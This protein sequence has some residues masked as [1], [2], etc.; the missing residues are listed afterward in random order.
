VPDAGPLRVGISGSY[1]GLN[2]GDEAILESMVTQLRKTLPVEITV[3]TRDAEDTRRR[4]NVEHALLVRTLSREEVLPHI[5]A[6]DLFLL[7]GGG[8]LFDHWVKL[9]L[10]EAVLAQELGI[11]VFVYAVS[12]GPLSEPTAVRAV[13][14]CLEKAVGVTVRDASTLHR[15]EEIG[16]K[17]EIMLT[18]DP[19]FL[20]EPEPL[21]EDALL[22]EGLDSGRPLVGC[23]CGS[24]ARLHLAW[25]L[26]TI[27]RSSPTPPTTCGTVRCRYR[28][29]AH[30]AFGAGCAACLRSHVGHAQASSGGSSQRRVLCAPAYNARG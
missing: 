12:A 16:V 10:R 26:L 8:I 30:G 3:F 24:R 29:R 4:H 18:A 25:S 2:L 19:A 23:P 5:K 15:L 20:L 9:F 21:P 13:R 11:P 7:G 6:L 27:T 28:F 1:G 22:R 14:T 17:R